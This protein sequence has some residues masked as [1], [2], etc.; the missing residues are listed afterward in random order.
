MNDFWRVVT[1]ADYNTR[2]VVLGV[3]VLGVAAG[4]VGSFTLLRKRA[5]L[6]DALAHAAWPGITAA[7]LIGAVLSST[8]ASTGVG[9]AVHS[10][11]AKSP[12]GLL[13]GGTAGG[14]IGVG[15]IVWLGRQTRL[16]Q[17]VLLGIVLSVFFG[18]G[19]A[20]FGVIQQRYG[21]VAGLETYVYGKA[22]SMA[23]ADVRLIIIVA[24]GSLAATL[25]LFKELRLLCFDADYAA[26]RGFPVALL[27]GVLM[28]MV[29]AV[30]M[31]GLR[32]VGVILIVAMLVTPAAAARFWTHAMGR[33]TVIASV[34]GGI[35]G[36]IGAVASAMFPRLPSGAMIVLVCAGL[37]GF[38]LVFG[39]AR[40]VGVRWV[41]RRNLDRK[42]ARQHLLRGIFESIEQRHRDSGANDG[43]IGHHGQTAVPVTSLLD[44]RS[45]SSRQLSIAIRRAE[46]DELIIRSNETIA[47]TTAG[48]A[49]AAR[50]TRQHRLWELYL[51]HHADVATA[52]VDRDADAIE[53]VL[54]PHIV[55]QLERLLDQ[56]P[57]QIDVPDS[58]HRLSLDPGGGL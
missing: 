18:A 23:W 4:V 8:D 58:V 52:R 32:A 57:V 50:L 17:D 34:I 10:S 29:V 15:F 11:G 46:A 27:D 25:L 3:A 30:T 41:R 24:V 22:A 14:L 37:F 56:A 2:I 12:L 7:F 6:G 48:Y 26:T 20:M 33:M 45:W 5:L 21:N 28:A 9:G 49:E 39:P 13:A 42:I 16:K 40:G 38:S 1:L 53:H 51:V 43:A 31:A 35:G 55:D 19:A 54:E 36:I 44:R 47:L